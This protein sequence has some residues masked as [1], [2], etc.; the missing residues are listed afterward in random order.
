[1]ASSVA[2]LLLQLK[3]TPRYGIRDKGYLQDIGTS[4]DQGG[5]EG[6]TKTAYT[7]AVDNPTGP[8]IWC[9]KNIADGAKPG[10]LVRLLSPY[11]P[12]NTSL[13]DSTTL[14]NPSLFLNKIEE[15]S[16]LAMDTCCGAPNY[17]DFSLPFNQSQSMAGSM[18]FDGERE[19]IG[20]SEKLPGTE[21]SY[22]FCGCAVT[23][24]ADTPRNNTYAEMYLAATGSPVSSSSLTLGSLSAVLMLM[25]VYVFTI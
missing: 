15:V 5:I 13:A 7:L 21:D 25:V 12:S 9:Y 6:L 18:L 22:F 20:T 3:K 10:E 24:L 14:A 4:F 11:L 19:Y 2:N 8:Y 17:F 23:E 1:M 16:Q